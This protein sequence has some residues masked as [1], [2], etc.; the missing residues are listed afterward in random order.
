MISASAVVEPFVTSSTYA[1]TS[2]SVFR[3]FLIVTW[4]QGARSKSGNG[5]T[6]S[7][8]KL[9]DGNEDRVQ[10]AEPRCTHRN[11][12]RLSKPQACTRLVRE[13]CA[14]KALTCSP[15]SGVR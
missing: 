1:L 12:C 11:V 2:S 13:S 3:S 9:G 6:L 7:T 4:E 10:L 15:M 8:L 14:E 5:I